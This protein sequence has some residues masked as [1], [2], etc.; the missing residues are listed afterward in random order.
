MA[1]LDRLQTRLAEK[2]AR[3]AE[4]EAVYAKTAGNKSYSANTSAGPSSTRQDFSSIGGEYRKLCRE[5]EAIED[6]IDNI[7]LA[8]NSG[9]YAATFR[10]PA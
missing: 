1:R 3:K 4:I 7:N 10:G 5:I 6:E 8:E 9:S 2:E